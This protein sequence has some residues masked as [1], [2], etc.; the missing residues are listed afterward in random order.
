[1]EG[2]LEDRFGLLFE[3]LDRAYWQECAASAVWP[4]F[5]QDIYDGYR[6]LKILEKRHPRRAGLARIGAYTSSFRRLQAGGP[7]R[8]PQLEI[9]LDWP[10]EYHGICVF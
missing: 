7:A 6:D 10:A 4:T 3:I 1:V 8:R 2:E 5:A 9:H